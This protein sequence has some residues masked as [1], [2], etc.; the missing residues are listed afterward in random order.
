MSNVH[1]LTKTAPQWPWKSVLQKCNTLLLNYFLGNLGEH[2]AKYCF[3]VTH[4]YLEIKAIEKISWIS[5]L[6][7][8]I[9][10]DVW[11]DFAWKI[12]NFVNWLQYCVEICSLLLS[13]LIKLC[14]P[15]L[16]E[17]IISIDS[18]S[19]G[20]TA[21]KFWINGLKFKILYHYHDFRLLNHY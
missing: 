15:D 13:Q 10:M 18:E 12:A 2:I 16:F 5:Y 7:E 3:I 4:L 6:V 17:E 8:K 20:V 11:S 1:I 9:R 14:A 21:S 19:V